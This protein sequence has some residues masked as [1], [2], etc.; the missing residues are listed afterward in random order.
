MKRR[1][2]WLTALLTSWALIVSV[3]N[4]AAAQE[5][6]LTNSNSSLV[7]DDATD[8]TV[9]TSIYG[10]SVDASVS[11]IFEMGLYYRIGN[12][13]TEY[14]VK[15]ND[16]DSAAHFA[17]TR[18]ATQ[19]DPSEVRLTYLSTDG[20]FNIDIASKLTGGATESRISSLKRK[21]TITNLTA[22]ALDFHLFS[23]SDFDLTYPSKL[24]NVAIIDG[25]AIQSGFTTSSE[26]V[27]RGV[28]SV[29]SASINPDLY[30]MD[31]MALIGSLS[32]GA[33]AY[34]LNTSSAGPWPTNTDV[35]YALQWNFNIPASGSVSFD[36]NNNIYP[37]KA[38]MLSRTPA[39]SQCVNFGQQVTYTYTFDN[40]VN[41]ASFPTVH[42]LRLVEKLPKDVTFVSA[43]DNGTLD[44]LTNSVVWTISSVNDAAKTVT[45][46]YLVNSQVPFT[47]LTS[48]SSDE[49]YP[50]R[51]DAQTSLC[52]SP[53]SIDTFSLP[54]GKEGVPYTATVAASDPDAGT[55]LNYFLD[56]APT[57]MTINLTSGEISWTPTTAQLGVNNIV[58]RVTDGSFSA[59][60]SFTFTV[61]ISD[62]QLWTVTPTA[63]SNGTLSPSTAQNV[64]NNSTVSFLVTP[65][66]DFQLLSISGCGGTLSG[67]TYITGPITGNC[68]VTA[69]FSPIVAV[70]RDGVVIAAIGKTVPDI[71]DALTVLR[72]SVGQTSLTSDQIAHGDVAPLG[73]NGTPQGDGKLDISDALA[74]LRRVVGLVSWTP[75]Q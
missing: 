7:F 71:T 40:A 73:S 47:L 65:L 28:T 23:Y 38:L 8:N 9:N 68:S 19:P 62:T 1:K 56:T 35:Q 44:P 15:G 29:E 48:L 34:D 36:L 54:N 37:T 45:G 10:W 27:G 52:N 21:I 18:P 43:S 59:T 57:G 49:T 2:M 31:T 64:S 25:K 6:T 69:T 50:T 67:N 41:T 12:S 42:N 13:T 74:I 26:T 51:L 39:T 60:R 75:I 61:T 32:N 33:T 5:W 22:S 17:V 70:S 53:P 3:N 14:P 24:D 11:R 66:T 4:Q 20:R 46:T 30:E 55:V 63:V 72:Y 58:V 16:I